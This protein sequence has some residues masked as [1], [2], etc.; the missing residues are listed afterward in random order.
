MLLV[1]KLNVFKKDFKSISQ[2]VAKDQQDNYYYSNNSQITYKTIKKIG[3]GQ[4]SD[5]WL[6]K[7]ISNNQLYALKVLKPGYN[8]IGVDEFQF[9]QEL[10]QYKPSQLTSTKVDKHDSNGIVKVYDHFYINK[11]SQFCLVLEFMNCNLLEILPKLKSNINQI[12]SITTQILH[13]LQYMHSKD[14]I[15][16]DLKLENI[17]YDNKVVKVTD[18]GN[19]TF[20][21]H[22]ITD[23]IQTRQYR[24]PEAILGHQWNYK[25]DI[26][27]LGCIVFE[28]V[29]GDFLFDPKNGDSFTKD[30]DHIAQIV[31][32]LGQYPSREYLNECIHGEEV[33]DGNCFRNIK[34]LKFWTL[35][36]VLIEKYGIK[37]SL[38]CDF[39][40]HCLTFDINERWD[41]GSL[42]NHP[43]L[44]K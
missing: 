42:L 29:T 13:S 6:I 37:D 10:Q 36:N 35:N 22:H 19:A 31:E 5:V 3:E 26:W 32:L 9:F 16:T 7:S 41:A 27:S 39:L 44:K 21:H 40:L 2:P 4:F 43:W 20:D 11:S 30:E 18:L 28:L 15:H 8:D 14:V 23:H 34:Q 38:L 24:S 33:F 12:K 25:V 17:L 1:P